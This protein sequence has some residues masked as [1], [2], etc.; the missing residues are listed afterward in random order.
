MTQESRDEEPIQPFH[1]KKLARQLSQQLQSDAEEQFTQRR[2]KS[3]LMG[4]SY[5]D[6]SC[7]LV[8]ALVSLT[9]FSVLAF[10]YMSAYRDQNG[11]E[12]CL[13]ISS[14]DTPV[15][16][17]TLSQESNDD[18]TFDVSAHWRLLFQ[19]HLGVTVYT[20]VQIIV[21]TIAY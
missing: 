16:S 8:C 13:T 19:V 3:A 15:S 12:S 7:R 17:S 6:C 14:S 1:I 18:D 4:G 21:A 5:L 2:I 10:Y 20:I 9:A 11:L